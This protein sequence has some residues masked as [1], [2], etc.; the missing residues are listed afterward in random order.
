MSRA[1]VTRNKGAGVIDERAVAG[2]LRV[3]DAGSS[4]AVDVPLCLTVLEMLLDVVDT[5]VFVV[6]ADGQ[7]AVA[8]ARGV[9]L[10]ER[11]GEVLRAF[12]RAGTADPSAAD[13][14]L[15]SWSDG[16]FCG[17]RRWFSLGGRG[18]HALVFVEDAERSTEGMVERAARE[19]MLTTRQEAVFR[20]VLDGHSNKEIG[21]RLGLAA[22]TVEVHITTLFD[23]IGVDS[24]ARL[25]AQTWAREETER[26]RT[27]AP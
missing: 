5:S 24:R 16:P 8:N 25:I 7:L 26:R 19:W 13:P 20:L 4:A 18:S 27:L 10:L 17:K 2:W 23:K 12:L 9:A 22:R 14:K 21:E 15:A 6:A 1:S 3:P 11:H